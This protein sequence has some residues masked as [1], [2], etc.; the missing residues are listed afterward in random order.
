MFRNFLIEMRCSHC[1][2]TVAAAPLSLRPGIFSHVIEPQKC[3]N[4]HKP[5]ADPTSAASTIYRFT[6]NMSLFIHLR[7]PQM[8]SISSWNVRM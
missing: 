2:I 7:A 4:D 5:Y 6:M 8:Y 3:M 1:Q